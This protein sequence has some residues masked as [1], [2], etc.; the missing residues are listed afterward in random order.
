MHAKELRLVY[1]SVTTSFIH[2]NVVSKGSVCHF[3]GLY[4]VDLTENTLII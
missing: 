3:Q 2:Q 1:K 4:C